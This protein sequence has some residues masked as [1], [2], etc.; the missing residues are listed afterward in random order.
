M[1][2][3]T[4]FTSGPQNAVSKLNDII[5]QLNSLSNFTGDGLI[6]VN[7]TLSGYAISLNLNMLKSRL[8]Y[9]SSSGGES[10]DLDYVEIIESLTYPDP[11]GETSEEQ[12]GRTYYR[13][14]SIDDTTPAWAA[15]TYNTGDSVI[16]NNYKWTSNI[17]NNTD[18]PGATGV[19]TWDKADTQIYRAM[20][21]D[22]SADTPS[23]RD[24]RYCLPWLTV[25]QVVPLVTVNN[26]NN[27]ES[28][29]T[30]YLLFSFFYTGLPQ[31]SSL[32]WNEEEQ[33]V[34]AVF[35]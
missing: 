1:S 34:M 12:L 2:D 27:S 6:T 28:G 22:K 33:R 23:A 32:R 31:R 5:R 20:G 17:D 26:P 3:I 14:R 13:V 16:H 18:E 10:F 7:R 19:T 30:S 15:G 8:A 11:T 25:G 21:F 24:L 4:P 35:S 9:N 29:N